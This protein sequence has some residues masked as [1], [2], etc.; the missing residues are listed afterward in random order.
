MQ[1]P[2]IGVPVAVT[3]GVL[4]L[5]RGVEWRLCAQRV[6]LVAATA[7]AAHFYLF[8]RLEYQHVGH[9]VVEYTRDEQGGEITVDY[10]PLE[11]LLED[12]QEY[13]LD[14]ES[15]TRRKIEYQESEA[16]IACGAMSQTAFPNPEVGAHEVA[17]YGKF[18]ADGG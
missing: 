12:E 14:Q 1:R 15:C 2:L 9:Q 5:I 8:A 16:E 6:T 18:E 7:H 11:Y 4:C 3:C 17:Q 13:H 10:I